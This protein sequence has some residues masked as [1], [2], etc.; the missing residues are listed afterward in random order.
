VLRVL[1]RETRR[2]RYATAPLF[3]L[4]SGETTPFLTLVGCLVSQ[5]VRDETT[6]RI[7]DELF[8]VAR[9]PEALLALPRARLERILRPA[10][11]YRRKALQLHAIARAVRKGGGVP[12]RREEL[13]RLPGIGPKCANIVL[14]TWFEAPLIAVDTHVHRISNRLG[15]VRTRTPEETEARLT[16]LVPQRWRARVNRLLVAHGQLVCKP[17]A[18]LCPECPVEPL[19]PRRGVRT[20]S[21]DKRGRSERR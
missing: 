17:L 10:G 5:R 6:A 2:G 9:T 3:R 16:P 14:A 18:P 21:I 11:F 7:C 4:A 15:W 20:S 8:A 1:A 19:C 12:R 13:L